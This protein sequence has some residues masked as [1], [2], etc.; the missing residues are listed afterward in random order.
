[1]TTASIYL[2]NSAAMSATALSNFTL[3]SPAASVSGDHKFPVASKATGRYVLIWLT[4][5]PQLA[6]AP[7]GAPPE[8]AYYEGQIYNVVV[9]GSAV[10]GTS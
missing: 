8:K 9:R 7:S 6:K 5:L 3:V 1:L 2:G 10:S 4:S